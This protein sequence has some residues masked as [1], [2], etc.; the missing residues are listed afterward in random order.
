MIPRRSRIVPAAAVLLAVTCKVLGFS[1][2]GYLR[3]ETSRVRNGLPRIACGVHS[4]GGSHFP[5]RCFVES[6]RYRLAA[7][8]Q[9]WCVR[10][11]RR[12]GAAVVFAAAKET[13]LA[14]SGGLPD[15]TS[16]FHHDLDQAITPGDGKDGKTM[17][18]K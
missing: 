11:Q 6:Q 4:E 7:R 10:G 9:G 16:A 15:G 18:I 13:S 12:D 17:S 2:Y 14:V 8:R 3:S 1:K 5:S